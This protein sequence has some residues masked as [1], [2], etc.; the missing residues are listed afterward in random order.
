MIKTFKISESTGNKIFSSNLF[1]I[2]LLLIFVLLSRFLVL[3]GKYYGYGWDPGNFAL[4]VEDYSLEN[5]R[6]HLPGYYLH[7]Q[8]IKIFSSIFNNHFASMIFLSILYTCLSIPFLYLLI[9]KWYSMLDSVLIS[10][11]I[12]SN[13]FSWFYGVTSEIY[14]FDLFFSVVLVYFSLSQKLVIYSPIILSLGTG[15]RPTSGLLLAPLFIYLWYYNIKNN[16]ISIK[17]TVIFQCLGILGFLVWFIPMVNSAGGLYSYI[18][19]YKTVNPAKGLTL[20]INIFELFSYM[21]FILPTILL[22]ILGMYLSK[23]DNYKVTN[24][25]NK[26]SGLYFKVLYYWLIPSILCYLLF[27]YSKGYILL[28][29][30]ALILFLTSFIRK[31]RVRLYILISAIVIQTSVFLFF[32]YRTPH[33]QVYFIRQN[34]NLSLGKVWLDRTFSRFNIT[35]SKITELHECFF[36][37]DSTIH[38]IKDKISY[39]LIDPTC[40]VSIRALQSQYPDI[41]FTKLFPLEKKLHYGILKGINIENRNDLR[42]MIINAVVISSTDLLDKYLLGVRA[43]FIV[44]ND[45]WSSF[46]ISEV[47]VDQYINFWSNAL[48]KK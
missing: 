35:K 43:E 47:S 33:V 22:F 4:A 31:S 27:R 3:D 37:I 41:G 28:I 36:V 14:A 38:T 18:Q 32:P 42:S 24:N 39:I 8:I 46:R 13:P 30:V 45:K 29:I 44:R 40:I 26:N 10:L 48:I 25:L 2:F 23:N 16:N 34:R 17:K 1:Y 12:L 15:I 5:A 21:M 11:V 6:P 9:R 7:I 19:L 20:P